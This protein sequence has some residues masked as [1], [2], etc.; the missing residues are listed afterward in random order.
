[1]NPGNHWGGSFDVIQGSP[2]G[3]DDSH[4]LQELDRA[5]HHPQKYLDETQQSWLLGPKQDKKKNKYV[6]LGC[7]IINRKAFKWILISTLIAFILIA[8]P[9]IIVNSLPKHNPDPPTLDNYTIAL[10]KALLFFNAQKCKLIIFIII[11]L[12]IKSSTTLH[13]F[14]S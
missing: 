12:L 14:S 13:I 10:Q 6:D 2:D 7:V 8:L 1:M 9:L 5:A 11:A 4:N 3:Q